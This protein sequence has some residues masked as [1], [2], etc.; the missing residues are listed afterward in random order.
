MTQKFI[1]LVEDNPSYFPGISANELR[2]L[3]VQVTP[4]RALIKICGKPSTLDGYTDV[5]LRET[6]FTDDRFSGMSPTAALV[7]AGHE[8]LVLAGIEK[9]NSYPYSSRIYDILEKQR[10]KGKD[11][12]PPSFI[13]RW[14]P[15]ACRQKKAIIEGMNFTLEYY[16][17]DK[18][19]KVEALNTLS[20]WRRAMT[21]AIQTI[22]IVEPPRSFVESGP[23]ATFSGFNDRSGIPSDPSSDLSSGY[24]GM[25][26]LVDA[27]ETEVGSLL[28]YAERTIRF[29]SSE[30]DIP[31]IQLEPIE[32]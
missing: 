11:F 32:N 26:Q 16:E 17:S 19:T 27:F 20:Q 28:D 5:K 31:C 22:A 1:Q 9:S 14:G 7:F 10:G 30:I 18:I 23:V 12:Y 13:C 8:R 6:I 15:F 3:R 2:N 4:V 21:A 25:D 29:K 24:G